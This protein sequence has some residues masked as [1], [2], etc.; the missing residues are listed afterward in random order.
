MTWGELISYAVGVVIC[1]VG[2]VAL[3]GH[4][5][6]PRP[7]DRLLLWLGAFA[8]CYGFR[9]LVTI[10]PLAD[11]L[12]SARTA[13][14]LEWTIN[15]VI[16]VPAM[17]FAEELY[18]TGWRGSLRWVTIGASVY[19]IAGIIINFATGQ[20]GRVPDPAL[21]LFAP[22]ILIVFVL[23]AANGYQ[24]RPFPEWRM[25]VTGFL[26]F[27]VFVLHEHASHAGLL[28][29]DLRI[30]PLGV[31]IFIG[32]LA[33]IAVAR[34]FSGQRQLIALE[35]EME[36]ARQIQASILPGQ[37][38]SVHGV[39]LAVRYVPLAAVAGDFYD[40]VRVE[41]GGI[42]VLVAD[43]SG[44]GV[45]AAL[46]ASMVKVAFVAETSRTSDPGAVLQGM[47][48][49]LCGMFER[50]Y[51][52]AVCATIVPRGGTIR[53]AI[54]GHPPPLLISR[55]G[56]VRTLD[57]RG[58]FIGM[59]PDATYRTATVTI[60]DAARLLLYTDGLTEAAPTQSDELFG[61]ER[62]S[63]LAVEERHRPAGEFTDVLLAKV[64]AFT[65]Q[66]SLSHDDV[67]V[68]VLDVRPE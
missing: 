65:G 64:T 8:L 29:W 54:A 34:F 31:L 13:D 7:K 20:P 48:A 60:E 43:V 30:E 28:P 24:P 55:R 53:Y 14:F 1:A 12:I 37:L 56:D 50:A 6:R 23:G 32:S 63:A 19:A 2:V 15:Y 41:D 66:P 51:V 5:L 46:I 67:T 9:L 25:L 10:G 22:G 49:T 16:L 11:P 62:L 38:P 58:I 52:T 45:P 61:I 44:H 18:G 21:I 40:V 26:V 3:L 27:I 33:Y 42:A 35:Q 59:F 39:E 17:L 36:A 57:E 47:N 4:M 68:V